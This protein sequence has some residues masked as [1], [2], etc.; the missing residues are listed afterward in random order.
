[1]GGS[2]KEFY[3]ERNLNRN[4]LV[5]ENQLAI[6]QNYKDEMLTQN[7]ISGLIPIE[8]RILN[9]RKMY[10]YDVTGLQLLSTAFGHS[11]LSLIQLKWL[12]H[13]ILNTV[14]HA[15]KYLL[16]EN[17]FVLLPEQIFVRIT[18]Q[19]VILCYFPDYGMDIREQ[20]SKLLEYFMSQVEY[21]E[22]EA[23]VFIYSMYMKSR[24]KDFTFQSLYEILDSKELLEEAK[25]ETI[26]GDQQYEFRGVQEKIEE[27]QEILYYPIKSY[28]KVILSIFL[29]ILIVIVAYQLKLFHNTFGNKIDSVKIIATIIVIIVLN[30]YLFFINFSQNKKCSKM[31][32]KTVYEKQESDNN[33]MA[34][35]KQDKPPET[36][37]ALEEQL[38]NSRDTVLLCDRADAA[39]VVLIPEIDK[40]YQEIQITECPFF[41]GKLKLKANACIESP[42]ISKIH[43][44]IE[45][46]DAVYY[47]H[48]LNSTNGSKVN[49][50]PV[51][52]NGRVELHDGD[53]ISFADVS[54]IFSCPT[55]MNMIQFK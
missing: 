28:I 31:I 10:Y 20:F 50:V 55:A 43:A 35:N 13:S 51:P 18:R 16:E 54:Y 17:D 36:V 30:I 48:D 29:S 1:M 32:V 25:S 7:T 26:V 5:M 14:N 53:R 15:N 4:Y 2:V 33:K 6:E 23:V 41:I 45:K 42:A 44:K 12:L 19:E 47:L 46:E 9:N 40:Q 38:E 21:E 3:Y 24:E 27:E 49:G 8:I 39:F 37:N 52:L 11:K 34:A 22:K